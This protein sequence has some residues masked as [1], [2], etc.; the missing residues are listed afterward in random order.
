MKGKA[1]SASKFA[2][3]SGKLANLKPTIRMLKAK[4][5]LSTG[6]AHTAADE[7]PSGQHWLLEDCKHFMDKNKEDDHWKWVVHGVIPVSEKPASGKR[8][9][10]TLKDAESEQ[11]KQ[12]EL[13][14]RVTQ[15]GTHMMVLQARNP[16]AY[17]DMLTQLAELEGCEAQEEEDSSV[18]QTTRNHGSAD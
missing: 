12:L 7:T 9:L 13:Q 6:S 3:D 5:G 1:S 17:Q 10:G 8:K 4:S 16:A 2:K 18:Q 11:L 15:L 14:T